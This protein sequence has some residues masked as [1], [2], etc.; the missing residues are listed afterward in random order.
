[1]AIQTALVVDDSRSAR[2]ILQRVLERQHIHVDG[3]GSADEALSYLSEYRPDVV[4]MDDMMPGMEGQEAIDRL[5]SNPATASIPIIMYTGRYFAADTSLPQRRG[6]IGVLS[7]PFAPQDVDALLAKL[8]G[9]AAPP[10]VIARLTREPAVTAE[11]SVASASAHECVAQYTE[12]PAEL[13]QCVAEAVAAEM[14][15][16]RARLT[17]E[18]KSATQLA[19]EQTLGE[20]LENEIRAQI[21]EHE[22]H[23]Q[24][25]LESVRQ[26]QS[27][28]QEQ[29]LEQRVPRL[30]DILGQR[31]QQRMD[32]VQ[33]SMN[34][35]IENGSLG[36][37]QRTQ[38]AHI[39]STTATE[40]AQRPARQAA[41]HAT[42]E[43]MRTDF[44]VLSLRV[45]RLRQRYR[46]VVT[47]A[48]IAVL[49]AAVVGYWVGVI[50]RR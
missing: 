12:I 35:R 49:A 41:R 3:V 50:G 40:A 38:V 36:P 13:S 46:F 16:E 18:I 37:L 44:N 27:R 21:E 31:L 17:Q 28:F 4:F 19:I 14:A 45:A 25:S 34:E 10:P 6:V 43:L 29:L 23:W 39:A 2:Y 33:K 8:G 9:V 5:A 48:V 20:L 47:S 32:A 15:V 11:V 7:K 22:T 42:A 24:H 30:L 1:M 26:A